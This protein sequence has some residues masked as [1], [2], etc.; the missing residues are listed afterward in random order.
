MSAA[1]KCPWRGSKSTGTPK[2]TSLHA[3]QL[4]PQSCD[5]HSSPE[6]SA[7]M[8]RCRAVDAAG[9]GLLRAPQL[10]AQRFRNAVARPSRLCG[11]R[12]FMW[13]AGYGK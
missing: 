4:S 9:F 1:R 2:V 13:P 5:A 6:P 11:V 3:R 7:T 12:R 10:F 8:L